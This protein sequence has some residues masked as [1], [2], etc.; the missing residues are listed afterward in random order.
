MQQV[1]IPAKV[2]TKMQVPDPS[3]DQVDHYLQAWDEME[4]YHLQEDALDKL[5]HTL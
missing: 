1:S 3:P 2:K 4:S 5:Y